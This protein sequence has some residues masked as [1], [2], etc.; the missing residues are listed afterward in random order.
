MPLILACASHSPLMGNRNCSREEYDQVEQGFEAL[1]VVVRNFGPELIF[2]FSPDHFNGF[3]YALMPTFCVGT[4]AESVGDFDTQA[5]PLAV[6]ADEALGLAEFLLEQEL[7]IAVSY[8]MRVDHGFVQIWEKLFG[9][10]SR[11]P[12]V[13]IFV[14]CAAP[15]LTTFRRARLLGEAVGRYALATG[16]R[17]VIAASGGL[18]HDPP[19]PRMSAATPEV[20]EFLIKG[21][22][23]SPAV[24]ERHRDRVLGLGAKALSG[25]ADILPVSEA[26]DRDFLARLRGG[27]PDAFD[28]MP[29]AGVIEKAGR[30]GPEVLCWVAAMAAARQA[31]AVETDLHFYKALQGWI[32]GLAIMSGRTASQ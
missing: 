4:A 20:R 7:D 18:S 6:P 14:N 29:V 19:V 9:S 13:P 16:K 1:A 17:V 23:D 30:G 25:E 5:G 15:P 11:L 21:H 26:W 24:R 12:I 32:A 10:A 31:G 22:G 2:Q 8:R 28:G 3:A 27:A